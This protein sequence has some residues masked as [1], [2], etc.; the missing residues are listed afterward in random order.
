MPPDRRDRVG[1]R[2]DCAKQEANCPFDPE[3]RIEDKC[4][5]DRSEDHSPY[6]KKCDYSEVRLRE[7]GAK[8]ISLTGSDLLLTTYCD[9]SIIVETLENT[10]TYTPTISRIAALVRHRHPLHRRRHAPPS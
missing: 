10:N 3:N 7:N 2:Y 5:A 6:G 4:H 9:V 8:V 1:G